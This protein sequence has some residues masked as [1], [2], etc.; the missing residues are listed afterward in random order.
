MALPGYNQEIKATLGVLIKRDL[1][2]GIRLRTE[3]LLG[4]WE[5]KDRKLFSENLEMLQLW[6]ATTSVL[7][8][9]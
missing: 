9:K 4:G 2:Q 5:I 3:N 6:E 1:I 8:C 7:C